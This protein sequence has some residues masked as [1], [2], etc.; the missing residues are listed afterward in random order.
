MKKLACA[1]ALASLTCMQPASAALLN[2]AAEANTN[3]ERGVTQGTQL[4]LGGLNVRLFSY[5]SSALTGA[6]QIPTSFNPYLD[7]G[8]SGLGVCKALDS[9]EQCTPTS[10][11]IVGDGEAV[12][13][14]FV[15]GPRAI[16]SLEFR[17][18][19]KNLINAANDGRVKIQTAGGLQT[20]LFSE[21]MALALGADAFFANT[22]GIRFAFVDKE[23]YLSAIGVSDLAVP[24]PAALP[25]LLTG[26][27]AFGFVSRRKKT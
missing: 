1:A 22:N 27:G 3:G 10:D 23:F 14:L 6:L 5:A 11:S 19:N 7:A 16:T 20:L 18:S 9:A 13:L 21:F 4:T 25:L 8:G 26:L 15:N 2:F 17:D 12:G 24:L